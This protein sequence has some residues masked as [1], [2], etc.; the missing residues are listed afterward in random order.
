VLRI[1]NLNRTMSRRR[2]PI[3]NAFLAAY[4]NL[5]FTRSLK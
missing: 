3:I 5:R 2:V 1:I 4:G